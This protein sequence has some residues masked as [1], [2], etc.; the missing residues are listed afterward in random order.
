MSQA[1]AFAISQ[2]LHRY[3]ADCRAAMHRLPVVTS[4]RDLRG[5]ADVRPA[6]IIAAVA[7]TVPEHRQLLQA[8]EHRAQE[9]CKGHLARLQHLLD[10]GDT[11]QF[12]RSVDAYRR[13]DWLL[14]RGDY[15]RLVQYVD[16]EAAR[17]EHA[18]DRD[19][20]PSER[21]RA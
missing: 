3:A 14:L 13:N 10:E 16:R 19:R 18:G 4:L 9:I 8:R 6:A 21:P 2:A 11:E 1:V 15:P 20:P 7:R 12:R 5:P 17:L